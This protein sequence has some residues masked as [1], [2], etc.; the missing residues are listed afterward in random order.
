MK[1]NKPRISILLAV[2]EPNMEWLK[3][4]LL[5]LNYQTYPNLKLYI[6]DDCSK[7]LPFSDICSITERCVTAF[8]FEI[9]QNKNNLGSNET[10][11]LLTQAADGDYLAYCDQ[12]DV[13][14]PEKLTT[15]ENRLSQSSAS[16]IFSDM[17][18]IDGTG[19]KFADSIRQ[20]RPHHKF[21][22]EA[23]LAGPLLY[24]NFVTGCTMLVR[25]ETAQQ[26]LPFVKNMYHDHYLAIFCA[27]RGDILFQDGPLVN[28]RIH[29][30]NQ[31]GT[32]VGVVDRKSYITY[33]I[34]TF[35][36]QIQEISQRLCIPE[37]QEALLWAQ[38]RADNAAHCKG[39]ARRLW[40][41]RK[42][43]YLVSMFELTAL[44]MP[45][46]LIKFMFRLIQSG[47]I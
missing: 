1:Q 30:K 40:K 5:S 8:P 42:T 28:Y 7:S 23:G 37:A 2:Y 44:K 41:Y 15:L 32:L 12:D 33:Q 31:S 24:R 17:A 46:P 9:W 47:K 26:A 19:R 18:L 22:Q 45:E 27:L 38:A 35:Y 21:L 10:F 6:L 13:W 34:N 4:Q 16:L 29:D 3:A 39:G 20:T 36:D 14:A 25:R 11:A 43:N